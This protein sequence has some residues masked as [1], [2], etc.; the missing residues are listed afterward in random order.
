M[1]KQEKDWGKI[2]EELESAEASAESVTE[3][4]LDVPTEPFLDIDTDTD[5][6]KNI[7]ALDHPSYEALEQ[8]LTDAEQKVHENWEKVVRITAEMDNLR[9]RSERDVSNAH[10]YGLEK[11]IKTLLPVVDSLEQAE[12][13]AEKQGDSAMHEGIQLTMKLLVDMLGKSNVEQMNPVGDVFNPE[14][15]EAMTMQASPEATPNTVLT[16]FQKGYKLNDRVIRAAR[17]IVAK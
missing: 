13:L 7:D 12:L 16:V 15:H 8:K 2:K 9:R 5:I 1:S 4:G 17:V 10:R 14:L 3:E 6:D 11:F